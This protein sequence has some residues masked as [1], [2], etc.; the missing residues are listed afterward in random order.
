MPLSEP[1]TNVINTG[2]Q[3]EKDFLNIQKAELKRLRKAERNK[4][5]MIEKIK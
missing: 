2:R 4:K 5:R 1:K 3:K